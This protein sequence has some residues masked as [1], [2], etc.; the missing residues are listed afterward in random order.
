MVRTRAELKRKA[1]RALFAPVQDPPPARSLEEQE[2]EH[3]FFLKYGTRIAIRRDEQYRLNCGVASLIAEGVPEW[4]FDLK[5]LDQFH[6]EM[7]QL[8]Y[9]W[10]REYII[11][12]LDPLPAYQVR[13]LITS[14]EGFCVQLEWKNLR[15]I[16][17]PPAADH[18]GEILA[19]LIIDI[20]V[21][22]RLF[23]NPFWYLDGKAGPD[24]P[25]DDAEFGKKLGYLSE[26]FYQSNPAF[27]GLWRMLG[28]RLANSVSKHH[29]PNPFVGKLNDE[30]H[31]AALPGFADDLLTSEPFCWLLKDA[32]PSHSES[33]DRRRSGLIGIFR[34]AV[35][36][37]IKCETYIN[38]QPVLRGIPE[39]SGV[40]LDYAPKIRLHHFCWRPK[41][42][43]YKGRDI[44]VVAQPGLAYVDHYPCF[45]IDPRAEVT[46]INASYVIPV[47]IPDDNPE[48]KCE[49]DAKSPGEEDSDGLEDEDK[50]GEGDEEWLEERS[51]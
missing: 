7:K 25:N 37:F 12:D 44:L 28:Q 18:F 30:R 40:F 27:G 41:M 11:S 13:R 50:L 21:H 33:A 20:T 14:V 15:R 3:E 48:G 22:E 19:E 42:D 32:Y 8:V 49:S 29:S 36:F 4:T 51:D 38:G 10:V 5:S 9:V 2:T 26:R 45:T 39:L 43:L 46:E 6:W 47:Y 24:D 16:L 23:Q 31:E 34:K 35:R 17:P 1:T